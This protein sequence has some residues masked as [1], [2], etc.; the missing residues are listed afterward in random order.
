[1]INFTLYGD[2]ISSTTHGNGGFQKFFDKDGNFNM[3]NYAIPS[4]SLSAVYKDN[5]IDILEN[6][7]FPSAYD[8]F[9]VIWYGTNDW[10]WGSGIKDD[11][12]NDISF[13]KSIDIVI[14][15]L[16]KIINPS[17]IIWLLPIYRNEL[18]HTTNKE[19]N[20]FGYFLDDYKEVIYKKSK[21]LNFVTYD[22]QKDLNWNSNNYN[23]YMEDGTH[24]NES[25][26]YKIYLLLK[27]YLIRKERENG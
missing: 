18:A 9:V 23:L 22:I 27:R 1:M 13:E 2:S 25:G 6:N 20:L 16:K 17:R 8:D 10:F 15:K 21:E 24:P 3:C 5:M 19:Y 11:D 7:N 14:N 4:S 12:S 26:C